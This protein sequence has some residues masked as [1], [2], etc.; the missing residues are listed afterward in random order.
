MMQHTLGYFRDQYMKVCEKEQLKGGLA[1]NKSLEDIARKHGVPMDEIEQQ[2]DMGI[3][4]EKEHTKNKLKAIEITKDHLWENPKYYSKLKKMENE[5]VERVIGET[6]ETELE[7]IQAMSDMDPN[8]W[9]SLVK[10]INIASLPPDA[11][12]ELKSQ[13]L[14]ISMYYRRKAEIFKDI[15]NARK[16]FNIVEWLEDNIIGI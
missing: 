3:K 7:T 1:D 11:L 9:V 2:Y 12:E 16:M 8:K 6:E 5:S 10:D 4:V 13:A 15:R 14:E